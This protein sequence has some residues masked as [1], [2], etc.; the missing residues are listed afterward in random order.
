VGHFWS[1]T[2]SHIYKALAE[3]ELQNWVEKK[4][5]QQEGKP[6]RNEYT[7]TPSG[8]AELR[9]WLTTPLPVEPVREAWLI[10]IF[11]SHNSTNGEITAL[12]EARLDAIRQVLAAFDPQSGS[13]IP[14]EIPPGLERA[15][16][17][18][19]ITRDYGKAFYEFDL[20]WHEQMLE[21][22]KN[23]PEWHKE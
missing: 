7:I 21:R 20:R 11:F 1:A 16:A 12:L 15:S 2:Q 6:N 4:L 23:L 3:L 22:I 19:Q 8:Q 13:V 17:L 14:P 10:Q 9:L 5:I 18:W